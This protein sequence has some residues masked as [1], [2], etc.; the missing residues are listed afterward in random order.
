MKKIFKK[1]NISELMALNA[2][3]FEAYFIYSRVYK[4]IFSESEL[5]DVNLVYIKRKISNK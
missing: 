2:K 1:L 4:S 5:F 3:E